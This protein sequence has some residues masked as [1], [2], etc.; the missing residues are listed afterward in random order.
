MAGRY[1]LYGEIAAGGMATVYFGRLLGSG[2][3]T[4]TVAVKRMHAQFARDPEFAAMFLDEARLAARIRH[5]NVVPTLDVVATDG[6]IFLVLEYVHGESLTKLH[7]M[8]RDAGNKL[9]PNTVLSILAGA[10]HGLHA[11]HEAKNER[12]EPLGIV[13]R[14]VSPQNILVGADGVARIIDFGVAKAA[15]RLQATRDGHVKGKL[16]YMAP[17]QLHNAEIDRRTDVYAAGVVLWEALAGARL[18]HADSEAGVITKVLG[19]PIAPPSLLTPSISKELDAITMR[20]LDRDRTK[21]FQT[22]KEFALA[23]EALGGLAMPSQVGAWVETVATASLAERAS[24][25]ERI[26]TTSSNK[27]TAQAR[28]LVIALQVSQSLRPSMPSSVTPSQAPAASTRG[29]TMAMA[30]QSSNAIT[31][32]GARGPSYSQP[33]TSA[34]VVT[35]EAAPPSQAARSQVPGLIAVAI[36]VAAVAGSIAFFAWPSKI[37]R[38]VSTVASAPG[39]SA[40]AP[41]AIAV[42]APVA[43]RGCGAGM[44]AVPAGPFSMGSDKPEALEAEGPVHPVIVAAF[45]IDELEVTTVDYKKCADSGG[46]RRAGQSNEWPKITDRDRQVYDSL[47]NIRAPED[48]GQHPINC[49][50][51]AMADSY[52]K[53]E[54]KHLPTEAQWELAA[55]GPDVRTYP[56]GDAP[57][58]AKLVNACG[59][60]CVEWGTRNR[61]EV[62]AAY[63]EDD[64][65]AATAPVGSFPAGRSPY[66]M[67]D[68]AGNVAEWVA[69]VYAAYPR[70]AQDNP[71]A[72]GPSPASGR[73]HVVRGGGWNGEKSATVRVTARA[74]SNA[75]DRSYA[76]GFRCAR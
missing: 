34:G 11:A 45:C 44:V 35:G 33:V 29:R 26:E 37:E 47:C 17:E 23:L 18:F 49:V 9:A 8:T 55:R 74:R 12:G 59:K 24:R 39:V 31:G 64:R 42:A 5:P 75:D 30:P 2:G 69:D 46:C 61:V 13:H 28:D 25:M 70:E 20:A 3:F 7:K 66:G 15:G 62:R 48:R 65:W 27:A 63:P 14:D 71:L 52:C 4:R 38:P 56:W 76:I 22:A 1:A 32:P 51:W 53:T 21:R 72:G 60:E 57:P 67:Q 36:A 68:A 16:A 41:G 19:A 54:N 43:A 10:L 6:D 40:V 73:D 50:T 58:S